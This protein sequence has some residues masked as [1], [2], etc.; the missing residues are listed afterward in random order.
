[1]DSGDTILIYPSPSA[2]ASSFS[3]ILPV[4]FSN[5]LAQIR[6]LV[7]LDDEMYRVAHQAVGPYFDLFLCAPFLQ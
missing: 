6:G 7:R 3:C 4:R 1:M 5:G 2:P